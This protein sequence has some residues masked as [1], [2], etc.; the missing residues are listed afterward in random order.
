VQLLTDRV[1]SDIA[2]GLEQAGID[3]ATMRHRV[4]WAIDA[5][6]IS[7]LADRRPAHLS[8][9]ERQRVAIAAAIA[10]RPSLLVLDEPTSQLDP[11]GA[12]QVVDLIGKLRDDTG[13][14]VV[15]AEHRLEYLLGMAD[16]LKVM[17]EDACTGAPRDVAACV[18]PTPLPG[19]VRLARALGIEPLPLTLDEARSVFAGFLPGPFQAPPAATAGDLLSQV[20][21]V[22]V[23]LAG[24]H[25]LRQ[26]DLDVREGEIVALVGQNGSGKTTLLR[27]IAGLQPVRSGSVQTLGHDMR[28]THPADLGGMVGYVPQQATVIFAADRLGDEFVAAHHRVDPAAALRRFGLDG[29]V[30]RHPLDLSGGERERAALAVVMARSPR[31]L[32]LDEPTRGM[33]AWR[34]HDLAVILRDIR[35]SGTGVILATH[36][37]DLVAAC[38]TRVV[39][40]DRGR[41][42]ADGPPGAVLAAMGMETQVSQVFGSEY[43]TVDDVLAAQ[44]AD[45]VPGRSG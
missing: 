13:L 44:P 8:G 2:F 43:L 10:T 45:R 16:V 28:H 15:V 1:E 34:K 37:A 39:G 6:G 5:T 41:V 24:R 7:H 17:G 22:D 20:T 4:D 23:D 42:V 35:D 40:L 18:D 25:A 30:D 9:G 33:D 14:A 29:K 27:S 31:L 19:V 11:A 12:R 32:L 21:G 38:A 3:R 36:D 26:V